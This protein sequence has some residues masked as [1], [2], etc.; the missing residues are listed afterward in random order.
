MDAE[1]FERHIHKNEFT[2]MELRLKA[3]ELSTRAF[4]VGKSHTTGVYNSNGA[5]KNT[6][7]L[8]RDAELIFKYISEGMVGDASLEKQRET[9][10]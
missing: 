6:V 3:L 10:T 7:E 8:I 1:G 9:P 4:P 5:I 2:I